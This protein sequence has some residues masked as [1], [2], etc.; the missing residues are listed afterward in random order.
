M[1][2]GVGIWCDLAAIL[3]KITPCGRSHMGGLLLKGRKHRGGLW[4]RKR[5]WREGEHDFYWG[6]DTCEGEKGQGRQCASSWA[7]NDDVSRRGVLQKLAVKMPDCCG[8]TFRAVRGCAWLST[9]PDASINLNSHHGNQCRGSSKA[10][11][12]NTILPAQPCLGVY[13]KGP[14]P[15]P[16]DSHTDL[17]IAALFT[18]L[19]IGVSI[20]VH[21]VWNRQGKRGTWAQCHS[22]CN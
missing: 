16:R 2:L 9:V 11:V 21:W 17:H 20:D 18:M 10:K 8:V 19:G 5:E 3:T 1:A 12:S 15:Y 7:A 6:L 22:L 14:V 13:P 4:E